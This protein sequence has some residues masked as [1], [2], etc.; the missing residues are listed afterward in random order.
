[1]IT[2]EEF[3]WDGFIGGKFAVNLKTQEVYDKFMQECEK[4]GLIWYSNQNPTGGNH[5][6]IYDEQ[7]CVVCSCSKMLRYCDA[8]YYMDANTPIVTYPDNNTKNEPA[9][10]GT[11]TS[12]N[13]NKLHL[14]DSTKEQIC[15]AYDIADEACT[16]MLTIYECMSPQEQR[17]FEVGEAYGKICSTRDKLEQMKGG[18]QE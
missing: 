1:M 3:D 13:D 10:A 4:R 5:W 6:H 7:F 17:A 12:S 14:D 2:K 16:D 8:K 18:E 11:G 15:Q 9:P